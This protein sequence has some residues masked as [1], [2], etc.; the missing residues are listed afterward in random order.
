[1]KLI[2]NY[3]KRA[4]GICWFTE[5]KILYIWISLI[6]WQ[7]QFAVKVGKIK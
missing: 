4:L 5:K 3:P 6:R 7:I 2:T 1:M